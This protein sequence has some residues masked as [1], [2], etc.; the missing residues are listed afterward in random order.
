M[1]TPPRITNPRELFGLLWRHKLILV[2]WPVVCV[3][4]GAVFYTY[5]P[6][7]Y[8]SEARLF[9]R[10]GRESVGIDP[11]ATAGQ[12]M[13]LYTADRK[14]EVKSTQEIFKSRSVA[15]TVVDLLGPDAVLGRGGEESDPSVIDYAMMPL[16]WL[17]G[18]ISSLDPIS[19]RE[20]AIITIEK[21]LKVGGEQ[22]ATMIDVQ[23]R[24]KSPELAQAVCQAV[25]DV[26][27]QEYMRVHRNAES[28]PFFAEQQGRLRDQ[29]DK[30][31]DALR[32]AKNE[33]GL[34]SVDQRRATLESQFSAVE[35]D[36]LSTDQQLATAQAKIED[37]TKQLAKIPERQLAAKKS[38]PNQGADM[39]RDRLYE[40]QV[41]SMD[42]EARYNDNH[43]LVMAVNEQLSEAQKVLAEQAEER[44][45]TS[46]EVNPIHRELSMAMKQTQSEVA[47]LK[48]RLVELEKQKSAVLADLRA[49]NEQDLK[50]DQ[51]TREAD[52]ARDKY[53][54]YARTME[55]ARMDTELQND[56]ISNLST[57]Q[58]ATFAEKPVS[59]SPLLTAAGTLVLAVGGAFFLVQFSESMRNS[60]PDAN[61]APVESR[62]ARRTRRR[63][64]ALKSNGHAGGEL[65][66]V[67]K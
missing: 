35:L 49:V 57:A 36:R 6:R 22:Q 41:K 39:L 15:A 66:S 50:I 7:A 33:M 23:Y 58:N 34:S 60:R 4:L 55:E 32:N 3:A 40:L 59:P 14:D 24:A 43:P 21:S 20:A 17:R 56:H 61:T 27:Q 29:L 5:W 65:Q 46:D 30:A 19:D 67:P 31:L 16:G 10:M 26:A 51:L 64:L 54:Q 8:R 1:S 9:L 42:L 37:L 11:T 62:V 45:E 47:G 12:T 28:T 38:M 52:L 63:A 13:P 44:T 53:M 2:L 25:V 18:K 48:A